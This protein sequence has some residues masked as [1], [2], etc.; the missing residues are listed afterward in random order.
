LIVLDASAAVEILARSKAGLAAA[1]VL[2]QEQLTAPAHFDAEV[3]GAFRRHFRRG[4]LLR[5]DLD[6]VVARL[7]TLAVDRV[8]LPALLPAAHALADA[9]S[10]GDAFYVALARL[11]AV[12][13]VTADA[14]LGSTARRFVRV[15]V[16]VP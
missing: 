1:A 15:R 14:R 3:Y 13:L 16:I 9:L 8:A 7:V 5:K 4:L 6:D 11:R 2:A 12:E 10:T